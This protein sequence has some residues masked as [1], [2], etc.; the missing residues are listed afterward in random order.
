MGG[1]RAW[2]SGVVL[3]VG[4]GAG[5]GQVQAL[6]GG[7]GRAGIVRR[8]ETVGAGVSPGRWLRAGP[9]AFTRD[10]AMR[11]TPRASRAV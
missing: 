4:T 3:A 7:P 6:C 10:V 8:S 9:A 11:G 1:R 5:I 2:P